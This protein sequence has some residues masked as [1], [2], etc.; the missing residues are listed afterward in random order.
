[1]RRQNAEVYKSTG[2]V[3]DTKSTQPGDADA[4]RRL[5]RSECLSNMIKSMFSETR[6]IPSKRK[7]AEL[8]R[9]HSPPQTKQTSNSGSFSKML[10]TFCSACYRLRFENRGKLTKCLPGESGDKSGIEL[11]SAL[12]FRG[13]ASVESGGQNLVLS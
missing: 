10:R 1:M 9:N 5:S 13:N 6:M 7:Y 12:P 8:G 3:P 2:D 4:L 11:H